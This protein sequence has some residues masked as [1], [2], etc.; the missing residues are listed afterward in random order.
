MEYK[1]GDGKEYEISYS[2]KLQQQIVD[3]LSRSQKIQKRIAKL[4]T[5]T[6]AC[7]VSIFILVLTTLIVLDSRNAITIVGK[8]LFCI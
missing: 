1:D 2:Q 5:I 7:L 3:E 8:R 6:I 4:T